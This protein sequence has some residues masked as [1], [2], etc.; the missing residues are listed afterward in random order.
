[1]LWRTGPRVPVAVFLFL[2]AVSSPFVLLLAP[3]AL[4]RLFLPRREVP[5]VFLAGLLVQGAAMLFA[6]RTPYSQ[7]EIEPVQVLLASLLRVPV[8]ALLGSEQVDVFY[9]AYGNLVILGAVLLVG[10][11]IAA[12]LWRG[13]RPG[14]TLAVVAGAY[15]VLV[16]V[17]TLT[18][19][20]TQTLQVQQPGV[21]LVGQ[22]Y[23]IAPCLFLFTA[24]MVGLDAVPARTWERLVVR[25][26][27]AAIGIAVV[28]S[29][30][31]HL[32][33]PTPVLR[34]VP[35]DES[36]DRARAT[37]AAGAQ[38]TRLVHEPKD[39]FFVLPCRSVG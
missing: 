18:M 33:D 21:V 16:I 7:D 38:E 36:V 34:G 19:N 31:A 15:S 24:V 17:A 9:P 10:V 1:L 29:V 13:D 20:W 28:V 25:A 14:R 2:A 39:W 22:R 30:V 35:W 32:R 4:A 12:A 11:P 8:V 3:I 5:I 23:S 6:T 26:S 37:C 27:A